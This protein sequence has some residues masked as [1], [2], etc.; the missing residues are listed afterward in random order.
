MSTREPSSR[1]SSAS[2]SSHD[3]S[4]QCTSSFRTNAPPPLS[5]STTL[6]Q[7]ND[8]I[9][10]ILH[11]AQKS[12]LRSTEEIL[13]L[14][15]AVLR[16]RHVGSA[17]HSNSRNLSGILSSHR[18]SSQSFTHAAGG[19]AHSPTL[20]G[21][22]SLDEGDNA[23]GTKY[24][25]PEYSHLPGK[26]TLLSSDSMELSGSNK[27]LL[28]SRID[29]L[30]NSPISRMRN[31][32]DKS[33][34]VS[35]LP[36]KRLEVGDILASVASTRS[37][38]SNHG[39][40][41]RRTH[42]DVAMENAITARIKGSHSFRKSSAEL[43][44]ETP[45]S[46]TNAR[47]T[48]QEA[49]R[50]PSSSHFEMLPAWV[51]RKIDAETGVSPNSTPRNK[52]DDKEQSYFGQYTM[53]PSETIITHEFNRG[54]WTW[55]TEWSPDGK[56]LALATE[57]HSLAVVEAGVT[58]PVWK[59]IHDERIGKLKNDTTHTIRSIAWGAN[60][61]ALGG[62]GDAVTIIEPWFSTFSTPSSSRNN[63]KSIGESR[64]QEFP[65]VEIITETG[66]VGA[67]HW[68]KNSNILA[69]G[70]REDQCLIVEVSRNKN[71]NTVAS[72]IIHTI[73]RRDWV[74]AVKFSPGGTK[75]AIGDRSGLLSIYLFV[76]MEGGDERPALTLLQDITMDVQW[77]PDTK[78][79]YVGGE[80]YSIT[81][82]GALNWEYVYRIGRDRWVP[83]LAPSKGGSHIAVGGGSS[84]VTLLD[85]KQHW[86]EVTSLPVDGGIP[87]SAKW[88]PNDQ[89]LSICGQ[90]K[91]VII[92]ETSRRRLLKGKCL[93][94]KSTILAV[95]FS[96]NGKI[97]AVGNETG[98]ITFFDAHSPNFITIYETVVGTGGDVTIRWTST[99]KH[100]AIIS[101]T[102]FVLLDTIYCGKTGLHPKSSSK[103]LVRKVIQGGVNFVSL[104]LCPKGDY[105]ALTDGH[106]RI[107]NLQNDCSPVKVFEQQ[108]VYCTGWSS[109]GSVFAMVGKRESLSIYDVTS[110]TKEWMLLFSIS[111]SHTVLSLCWGPS[112]KKGLHYLAF[113]GEEKIVTIIEVRSSERTWETVFQIR[114]SSNINDLD[115]NDRGL[116]CIG[117][118][119]GSVSVVDLSYL[120][121]GRTV[122]EMSYNWQRQGVICKMKLTRNL[123]R[124]AITSLRWI[125]STLGRN[126]NLLA[127][128]GSDGIVEIIDLSE[129]SRIE[130]A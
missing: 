125:K 7:P 37:N 60:F 56:Y 50:L 49:N 22:G 82:I 85:V 46:V 120:M 42:A 34:G 59:V 75:L 102:T 105:V 52:N 51:A 122:S 30:A 95:E 62:T 9:S 55:V 31:D 100:V 69:I 21:M 24:S 87:L 65:V 63:S 72:N 11:E 96:P 66:F 8:D 121:S 68:R 5:L 28:L 38:T 90:F 33:S 61:I 10:S 12:E 113:G 4:S 119:E 6:S 126:C 79:V 127:I 124:N 1:T 76:V 19:G 81:V 67:L 89:Y 88:H 123:G 112:V 114:F 91:D 116:L 15:G 17:T 130:A 36:G 84:S 58:T 111:V 13:K 97:L 93:R 18:Y 99:G 128:G 2:A 101:G 80:D 16:D 41:G 108:N 83:F 20:L 117:D 86:K 103:F 71:T 110:S 45:S 14:A 44:D 107:L 129:R 57:N 77:S 35:A 39:Q 26:Y 64:K 104:A 74:N 25:I 48:N 29:G 32:D 115:W 109:D 94:S 27:T 53:H 98:L 40:A 73:E 78:Y 47:A 118:D 43:A 23:S 3:T 70:S 92:Y 106:T 54:D